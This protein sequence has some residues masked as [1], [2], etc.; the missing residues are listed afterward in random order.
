[1]TLANDCECTE[2]GEC[3]C[4][5]ECKSGEN[6]VCE[7]ACDNCEDEYI[8]CCGGNCGCGTQEYSSPLHDY[9]IDDKSSYTWR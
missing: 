4:V 9:E 2:S 8:A 6:P 5:D 7:C 3:T 1:M